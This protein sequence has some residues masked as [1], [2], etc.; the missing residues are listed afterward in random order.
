MVSL[1]NQIFSRFFVSFKKTMMV[2]RK[3]QILVNKIGNILNLLFL[4]WRTYLIMKE[5]MILSF[6]IIF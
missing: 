6:V 2:P 4:S 3:I 1:S 5:M